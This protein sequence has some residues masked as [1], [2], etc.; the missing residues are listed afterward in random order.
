MTVQGVIKRIEE[1]QQFGNSNFRKRSLIV[2]TD[3]QYPQTLSIDFLQ[4]NCELLDNVIE[5]QE[6]SVNVDLRG[7][8]WEN[9]EGELKVFNTVVGLSILTK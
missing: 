1:E 2:L 7:R 3:G 8:E 6:V 5:G 4:G 9:P